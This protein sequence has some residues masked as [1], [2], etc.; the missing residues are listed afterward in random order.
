[1]HDLNPVMPTPVRRHDRLGNLL[2]RLWRHIGPRRRAQ[3]VLLLALMIV[4]S[5]AEVLTIG[6]VL[7][8][9]M[10]LTSPQSVMVH[11]L[12]QPFIVFFGISTSGELLLAL[13]IAFGAASMIAGFLRVTLLWVSTHLSCR[14]GADL[15][16]SIYRRTLYQPYAVHISRNTSEVISGVTIK[17]NHVI[18]NVFSPSMTLISSAFMLIAIL[19]TLLMVNYVVALSAFVGFS[20]IYGVI[21]K[22]T[23]K[24][25]VANSERITQ[26]LNRA[27]KALQEGLGGIRD[28]LLDGSQDAYCDLYRSADLR[29]R[30]AQANT[31]F[32][33]QCPRY[34]IEALGMILIAVIA[35]MLAR[36]SGA[37]TN[38]LPMLG[39]LALGAQ[40]MLPVIQQAYA[41]W[42]S[43]YGSQA[44]LRDTLDL[45]DQPLPAHADE[46]SVTPLSF[47]REIEL[48]KLEFRYAPDAPCVLSK[49][50]FSIEKGTRIGFIGE[51]GSGKSTLLDIVMGLLS[52]TSGSL[53][54]DGISITT[55]NQRSW[56][57]LVAHV[58]QSIFLTDSSVAENIAFGVPRE[59]IDM[60]RV[61]RAAQQAQIG[62]LVEGW[63]AK[64]KTVVG[65]RGI[66]LS[67]G[68]R[69]RIGIA[70]ALYKQAKV[71]IFDEATSALD[72][73][74]E[75]SV[76]R[77]VESLGG[78][79]TIM[80]IAHRLSTLSF[81][82]KAVF[83]ALA[84]MP[85]S[86]VGDPS[87][88]PHLE[89][90]PTYAF[91]IFHSH[92]GWHRLLRQDL[93]PN[94]TCKVQS[95]TL[96]HL[97]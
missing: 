8:F 62:E 28:V 83:C 93:C 73:L 30:Y 53:K 70:R 76:M 11:P 60:D 2:M 87:R 63:P 38:T 95:R 96:D 7:P 46:S 80:I 43:I 88:L 69:Q 29:M 6:A 15:S 65:E 47:E 9:L 35:Y 74:T 48:V 45:L 19:A 26:E 39:A 4:A 42:I 23:R 94:D 27:I 1:M 34:M 66:K 59:K 84:A 5:F 22:L 54:V 33:S 78:D 37:L 90:G 51:T 56:Q 40:R 16:I 77:A 14:T 68:Q 44:P 52:P 61:R 18:S 49:I 67:G 13:T 79:L 72:N 91:E 81:C 92:Y 20:L 24:S 57:S 41:S 89:T 85:K 86:S 25:L 82:D 3:F 36:Q 50:D 17:A 32:I 58:P 12:T 55:A 21:I 75:E 31:L 97:L 10:V 71:I 64:Y